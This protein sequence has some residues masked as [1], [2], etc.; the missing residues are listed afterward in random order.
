MLRLTTDIRPQN[1]WGRIGLEIPVEFRDPQVLAAYR[2]EVRQELSNLDSGR[3]AVIDSMAESP[4]AK[5]LAQRRQQLARLERRGR[6]MATNAASA[7][8]AFEAAVAADQ[9]YEEAHLASRRAGGALIAL[10]EAYAKVEAQVRDLEGQFRSAEA[11]ALEAHRREQIGR[12]EA[13]LVREDEELRQALIEHGLAVAKAQEALNALRH[14]PH[15][16]HLPVDPLAGQVGANWTSLVPETRPVEVPDFSTLNR[17]IQKGEAAKVAW[18]AEKARQ[19]QE[20]RE[21]R[22]RSLANQD[23]FDEVHRQQVLES[24]RPGLFGL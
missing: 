20:E 5:A 10:R 3:Q 24:Q 13:D 4:E 15:T 7:S 16:A 1:G 18:K 22:V 21:G 19:A 2:D 8:A 9:P 23:R 6:E 11:A 14:Q 17:G 12:L